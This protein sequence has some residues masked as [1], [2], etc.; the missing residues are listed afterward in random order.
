[1]R[2]AFTFVVSTMLAALLACSKIES[3]EEVNLAALP[4]LD[5]CELRNDPERYNGKIVRISAQIANFGH[6][7]YFDDER[8]SEKIE[9]LLD[10]NRTA[11]ELFQPLASDLHPAL[12]RM[13]GTGR[14]WEPKR[15]FAVGRFTR[16]Y[17]TSH[18]DVMVDR[19]S[20]HFELYSI[21]PAT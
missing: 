13:T 7:Y 6:G 5:Y 20:F 17:P 11:V 1:M 19:T 8:C 4:Q 2:R 3:F 15:V 21:E 18:T 14:S 12:E 16:Q 9:N 10:D